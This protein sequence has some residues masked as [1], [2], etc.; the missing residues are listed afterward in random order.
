VNA[1]VTHNDAVPPIRRQGIGQIRTDRRW[2]LRTDRP[3]G[4]AS[5]TGLHFVA[6]KL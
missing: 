2:A 6:Q 5:S 1:T 3:G 4:P